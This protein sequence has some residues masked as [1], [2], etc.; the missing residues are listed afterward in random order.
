MASMKHTA[1]WERKG[2]RKGTEGGAKGRKGRD[3]DGRGAFA[4]LNSAR[5]TSPLMPISR[6]AE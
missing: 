2:C 3:L 1:R 5:A 4:F 6:H